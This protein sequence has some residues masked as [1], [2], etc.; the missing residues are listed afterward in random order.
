[1]DD[2]YV[3]GLLFDHDFSL[4]RRKKPDEKPLPPESPDDDNDTCIWCGDAFPKEE[5]E[6]HED[7]CCD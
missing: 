3:Q 5:L 6:Q 2:E 1:M 4:L 7:V